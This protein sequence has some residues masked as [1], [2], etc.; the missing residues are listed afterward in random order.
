M[1]TIDTFALVSVIIFGLLIG[2]FLNVVIHRVPRG[3]EGPATGAR[4]RCP[5]CGALIAWYDNVPILSFLLLR[6]R[7]R[8]CREPISPR[9]A[10]VEA[11]TGALFAA[12]AYRFVIARGLVASPIA[13]GEASAR[14]AFVAALIAA[15][16]IDLD[17]RIIPDVITIP[18]IML[19]PLVVFL[20]PSLLAEPRHDEALYR[21]LAGVAVG[22][23][24]IYAIGWLGKAIFRKD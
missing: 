10:V 2:S 22:G 4:S 7:C 5:K 23:G 6:G 19:A 15:T 12:V 16:F 11:L 17:F 13:W 1:D 21:S 9:Y 14:A 8:A 3:G 20:M 24:M 18:G